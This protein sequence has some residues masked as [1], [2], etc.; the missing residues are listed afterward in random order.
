MINRKKIEIE[1]KHHQQ[2]EFMRIFN[3]NFEIKRLKKESLT[4][5]LSIDARCAAPPSPAAPPRRRRPGPDRQRQQAAAAA[6]TA[7]G[8]PPHRRGPS[9]A[10]RA[11]CRTRRAIQREGERLRVGVVAAD[12]S[13]RERA[14]IWGRMR[15]EKG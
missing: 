12:H 6:A 4:F 13:M 8:M 2:L 15:R 1:T 9:A 5:S 14:Q 7:A 3:K 11:A 10:A